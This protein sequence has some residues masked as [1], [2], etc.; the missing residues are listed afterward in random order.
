[1]SKAMKLNE[2]FLIT[3]SLT[4]MPLYISI[5]E[6]PQQS[7][8]TEDEYQHFNVKELIEALREARMNFI[9]FKFNFSEDTAGECA[10]SEQDKDN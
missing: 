3:L 9:I 5:N 4:Q 10:S 8:T 6:S 7:M 2:K 1:M